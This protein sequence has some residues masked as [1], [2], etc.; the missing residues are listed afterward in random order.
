[1]CAEVYEGYGS[2]SA[3]SI[4]YV[5]G[6]FYPRDEARISVFDSGI[7]Y[8]DGVFEAIR[9]FNSKPFKQVEH[10]ERL[11]RSAKALGINIQLTK[12]EIKRAMEATIKRNKGM[13]N[14]YV[15]ILVTRGEKKAVGLDPRLCVDRPTVIIFAVPVGEAKSES[16]LIVSSIRRTPPECLDPKIKSINYLNNILAKIEAI[17]AGADDALMLDIRGFIAEATGANVFIVKEG[18]MATPQADNILDGITRRAIIDLARSNG[19]EVQERNV[20]LQEV[21]TA[22]EIFLTGTS[23]DVCAVTSVGGRTIGDGKLGPTTEKIM[24]LYRGMTQP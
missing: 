17:H 4:V 19:F 12:E 6:E 20:T 15:R 1:M 11:Y 18:R 5:N 22:D 13:E 2:L 9:L 10:I 14:A 7:L 16:S 23:E 21:Y 8:G 3:E 24:R